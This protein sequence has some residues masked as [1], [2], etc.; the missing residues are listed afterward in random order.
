M[1]RLNEWLSFADGWLASSAWFPWV[2]LMVGAWFTIYLGLPQF[3]F[4][5]R[6]WKVLFGKT[7]RK[8]APGDTSH[9]QAMSTALSG[10]VGTGNIGG[11]ALALAVGG[12][13]AIFWMWATAVV[14]MT[15]KFVEVTLSHKYREV[16]GKGLISG[17][18][19]YFMEKRL[20]MKP[21]AILFAIATIL[22]ALGSGNLPQSRNLAE[23]V[24]ASFGI[25]HAVTG[26][27]L[28]IALALVIVGGI[29]VIARV[30]SKIV[31]LMGFIYAL[32]ALAVLVT[33]FEKVGPSFDAIFSS[34]FTGS[35]TVA[36]YR[37]AAAGSEGPPRLG[38]RQHE[39]WCFDR[40]QSPPGTVRGLEA[41]P[42]AEE[43]PAPDGGP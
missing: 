7:T 5:G 16:D 19:M 29:K 40:S 36:G 10:T 23:G 28:A 27:V 9:F 1:D 3:R 24:E 37:G 26:L 34:A 42:P 18:P 14:G 32:G 12:P 4:F 22:S 38:P 43:P 8:E 6:A 11:V 30:T 15:T 33:N 25:P 39:L 17:G 20:K 2:L 13:A 35:A 31:P 41:I 21:L